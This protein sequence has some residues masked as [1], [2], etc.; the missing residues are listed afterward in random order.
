MAN[1]WVKQVKDRTEKVPVSGGRT[2]K[3]G[4]ISFDD[5]VFVP[6]QLTKR[7]V[8]YFR[9]K[10]NAKT[11][12]GKKS[13]RPLE[14][15][16]PIIFGGMSFGALSRE[17]KNA[18]AKASTMVGALKSTGEGGMLPE[19]RILAKKLIVEYSTG[20]FGITEEVL[21][22]A[23]VL[24]IK[25][26]QGA[27]PGQGGLLAK[28][29]VTDEI[30]EIRMV[31]KGKDVHSAPYHSDINS[32]EDLKKKVDWMRE[33]SGGV[34]IVIKLGAGDVENDVKLA[35]QA[36]PDVIAIDGIEGGT[37]A[38]PEIM[39]NDFGIP[40]LAALRIARKTLDN[41]GAEQELWIGGGL[42]KGADFAKALAMG[43]DAVFIGMPLLVA[44]GC[45]YCKMCYFGKCPKGIATQDQELRK[46]LNV[47]E[48]TQK[49][50]NYIKNCTE[51]IKMVA[52][53][54][55]KDDVYK[56]DRN[57]LRALTSDISK[58]SGI[59]LV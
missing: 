58:I 21:K 54:C 24:K 28:E 16:T 43:A 11:I 18:M 30:A 2:D 8:D 14:I 47:D 56:L 13:K 22:Q 45:A 51:E 50:A 31:E 33:L 12:V 48:A 57:D 46:N 34:P 38:A 41:L 40:A 26:G 1:E 52:G 27:K 4:K 35:V 23:D 9:D 20:R 39:L 32:I 44:M 17:A 6:A 15:E 49:I 10:I 29:K 5:L 3:L 53:A 19:S 25:I 42:S 59:D 36:G 7:P 37:G 55:G